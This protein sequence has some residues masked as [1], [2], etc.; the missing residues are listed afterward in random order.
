VRKSTLALVIAIPVVLAGTAILLHSRPRPAPATVSPAAP[1]LAGGPAAPAATPV[2]SEA[3]QKARLGAAA[4]AQASAGQ[5]A[6]KIDVGASQ[7]IAT[8]GGEKIT[9]RQLLPFAGREKLEMT[10]LMF[11]TLKQRAIDRAVTFREAAAKS[12]ELGPEQRAQLEAARKN[13]QARGET[14]PA[15]LQLEEDDA[16]ANLLLAALTEKAG[17]PGPFATDADVQKYYKEHDDE[18]DDLPKEPKAHAAAWQKIQLEIRQTLSTELQARHQQ[19]VRE[20]LDGLA[21]AA[22]VGP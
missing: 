2:G 22:H 1:V 8:V 21:A 3:A 13:A 14:D 16:R 11:A 4:L 12:I 17:I 20:Y 7:V 10:P 6:T 15:Q 9:G 19:R 5:T 18:F